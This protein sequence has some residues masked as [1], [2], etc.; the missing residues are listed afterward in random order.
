VRLLAVSLAC[1]LAVSLAAPGCS[2]REH[3]SEGPGEEA[4]AK[5]SHAFD[6]KHEAD[7]TAV[8]VATEEACKAA[9]I[10][11]GAATPRDVP[12][13]AVAH[14]VLREDATRVTVLRAPFG[15]EL[16]PGDVEWP[17]LGA[18]VAPGAVV[19]RLL[20][21]AQP[22][23]PAERADLSAKLADAKATRTAVEADFGAAKSELARVKE[24]N[25]HDKGASD[26]AVEAAAAAV[27]AGEAKLRAADESVAIFAKLL[28]APLAPLDPVELKIARGGTLLFSGARVGES[29][30]AGQELLRVADLGALLATVTLPAGRDG[31]APPVGSAREPPSFTGATVR[32]DDGTS[33]PAR[34]LGL[35]PESAPLGRTFLLEVEVG[36]RPLRP[37]QSVVAELARGGEPIHGFAAPESALV[38]HAGQSWIYVELEAGRFARARVQVERVAGGEVIVTGATLRGGSVLRPDTK[39]V[40]AGAASLLSIE[41]L[42]AGGGG[43]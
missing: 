26:R 34:I 2:R 23:T 27:A 25:A 14:G 41:Q 17:A 36:E 28:A 35:A 37:G 22:L 42:A 1:S 15:G 13:I 38:R 5:G 21:R 7:G 6:L 4:E 12:W 32:S 20:P 29:V 40:R 18:N 30:E 24:L 31:G 8:I 19:A 10:E 9:G 43:E 33:A 11:V 39:I 3:A 16:A